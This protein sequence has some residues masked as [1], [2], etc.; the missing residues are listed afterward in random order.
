MTFAFVTTSVYGKLKMLQNATTCQNIVSWDI[1]AYVFPLSTLSWLEKSWEPFVRP[2]DNYRS[3]WS[4]N[5]FC[6]NFLSSYVQ[7]ALELHWMAWNL[8]IFH[9]LKF[10]VFEMN[11]FK[12]NGG[13][14]SSR[15]FDY[16]VYSIWKPSFIFNHHSL[17]VALRDIH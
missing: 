5:R 1:C 12:T 4:R 7:D 3:I 15:D 6:P 8:M 13:P 16:N 10:Q 2:V 11:H 9:E 14:W 17:V